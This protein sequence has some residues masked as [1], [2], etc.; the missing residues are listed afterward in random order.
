MFWLSGPASLVET[1]FN[2]NAEQPGVNITTGASVRGWPVPVLN[3]VMLM[4]QPMN[5]GFVQWRRNPCM[6]MT[7]MQH[8]STCSDWTILVSPGATPAVTNV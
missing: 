8:S 4:V 6:C 7:F 3:E 5:M 1:P 2:N